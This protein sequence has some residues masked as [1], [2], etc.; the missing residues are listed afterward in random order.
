MNLSRLSDIANIEISG[1]DK[2]SVDGETPVRL[3]NFVDVYRNWAITQNLLKSFMIAS[4]KETE[5]AKCSIH[6]GQVAITK[7]SETRD[8]IGISAYIAD[9]FDDVLL[10]YHCAL[11][12]PNE[13]I[14]D[15][16]Y[17]NAFMHTSYIQKYFENNASGS[18]Q[19]YTL[20]NETIFQIPILLPSLRVQKAIGNLLSNIDRK[21]ELN[22]QI[23]DNLEKMAKQLYDY[24]FVQFDFPDEIGRPYKSSGGEM[25]WN[26]KLKRE[27]PACFDVMNLGNLCSFRNG[28][29]YTKDEVG[30]GYQIVNVRNISSSNIL[31][32]GEDFDT[33]TVPMAKAENY[34]LNSRDIIIARSGCPGSARLLLSP[35]NTLFCGFIICCSANDSGMRNYLTYCLKQLEGTK[36]TTSGGSI[37]QNVS[38]D[39]LKGLHIVVPTELIVKRFNEIIDLIF[40]RMLNC[41]IEN[42]TLT[43]QR[44]ELL[45]LLMNGQ[46]SLNYHLSHG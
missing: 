26:E 32:D 4:A 46:A 6:K 13:D 39:T 31:L 45:P 42:K 1:V 29:N 20:S 16:K 30:S 23:N 38:Q 8:D 37:L 9:D 15:G 17:L 33:I 3:C 28:I 18:G 25:V 41:L 24:W 19:R 22:R 14:L 7:D 34:I 27:V 21:I 40:A 12:T 2:K 36:A 35:T 10:G 43:K 11:I 44:D 5:I